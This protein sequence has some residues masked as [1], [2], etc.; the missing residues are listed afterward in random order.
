[1]I[2]VPICIIFVGTFFVWTLKFHKTP[3]YL[4]KW[5]GVEIVSKTEWYLSYSTQVTGRHTLHCNLRNK[6]ELKLK[7]Y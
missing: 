7:A 2:Y 6:I 5:G 4:E 1:V 3:L